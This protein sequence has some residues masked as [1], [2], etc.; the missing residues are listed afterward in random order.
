VLVQ[1][2]AAAVQ[3]GAGGAEILADYTDSELALLVR[4]MGRTTHLSRAQV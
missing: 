3:L 4:H 2:V 1:P